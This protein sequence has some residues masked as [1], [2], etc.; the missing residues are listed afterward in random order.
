[1]FVQP[2]LFFNL[3]VCTRCRPY[4]DHSHTLTLSYG[5]SLG[6]PAHSYVSAVA[7]KQD[8]LGV[9]EIETQ[10]ITEQPEY[11]ECHPVNKYTIRS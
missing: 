4:E 1:M 6:N 3:K 7:I 11:L 2:Q 8:I 9:H 10:V 5:D